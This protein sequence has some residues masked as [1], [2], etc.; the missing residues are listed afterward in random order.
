MPHCAPSCEQPPKQGQIFGRADHQDLADARQHEHG[1]R[2]V[3]HRL[4]VDRQ[5]LLADGQREGVEARA[6]AACEDD[7]FHLEFSLFE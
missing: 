4:V 3:H 5:Q 6:A 7:A 2:V 1:E